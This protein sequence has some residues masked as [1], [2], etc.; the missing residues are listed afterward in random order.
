MTSQ[1][2]PVLTWILRET[3]PPCAVE[4]AEVV[5]VRPPELEVVLAI[6]LEVDEPPV[7]PE[8]AIRLVLVELVRVV[9]IPVPKVALLCPRS[10]EYQAKAI[11]TTMARNATR[12]YPRGLRR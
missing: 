4:P 7:P 2:L 11:T 6:E 5:C 3:F 9:V 12:A 10:A 8:G 1:Q